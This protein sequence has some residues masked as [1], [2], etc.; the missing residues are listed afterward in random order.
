MKILLV[1][2]TIVVSSTLLS[3]DVAHA[4][5]IVDTSALSSGHVFRDCPNCPEMVVIPAGSFKMGSSSDSWSTP[6]HDVSIPA[7]F[8]V[9]K[10]E[11]T[12]AEWDACAAEGGCRNYRP[13]DKVWGRD[14]RPVI[15]MSWQ[16]AKFYIHW[17]SEKTGKQYRLLS[18]AEWEYAARA[19]TS[20]HFHF[21]IASTQKANYQGKKTVPVGSYPANA[22]GLHDMHGNVQE[23]VEDCWHDSYRDA[24]SDGSAWTWWNDGD[25]SCDF[26]V[27]RGGCYGFVHTSITSFSRDWHLIE[28]RRVCGGFRVARTLT[29]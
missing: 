7:R 25:W 17:L 11:V 2:L 24:P 22:F 21:G 1:A 12:F 28:D 27:M 20:G 13:Y 10:Y 18:E 4:E 23:W 16:D 15:H 29:P 3:G 9:G 19:G 5:S 8:A 6:E 26:R 14:R